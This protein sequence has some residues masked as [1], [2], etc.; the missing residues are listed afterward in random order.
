MKKGKKVY[1]EKYGDVNDRPSTKT[2][3]EVRLPKEENL[4]F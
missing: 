2:I 4:N 3:L 1:T